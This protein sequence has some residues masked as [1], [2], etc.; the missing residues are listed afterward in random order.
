MFLQCAYITKVSTDKQNHSIYP[1]IESHCSP[2]YWQFGS[3]IVAFKYSTDRE[4]EHVKS[5]PEEMKI[6]RIL[7]E[8]HKEIL[9][10][11]I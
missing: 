10:T 5:V 11:Q 2:M 9:Y 3:S 8:R 4:W 1:D 7:T 6:F